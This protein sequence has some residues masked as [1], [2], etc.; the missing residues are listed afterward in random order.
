MRAE[1]WT[2]EC[3]EGSRV[4]R[5]CE[6]GQ[7]LIA[8]GQVGFAQGGKHTVSLCEVGGVKRA[9]LVDGLR[10]SNSDATRTELV[11]I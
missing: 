10:M 9:V 5:S 3:D 6:R 2:E 7:K 1:N 4:W 11:C 8:G